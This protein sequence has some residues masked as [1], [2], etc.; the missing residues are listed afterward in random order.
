VSHDLACSGFARATRRK[1]IMLKQTKLKAMLV[2]T[3][4]AL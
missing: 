2:E 3:A 1:K 4:G